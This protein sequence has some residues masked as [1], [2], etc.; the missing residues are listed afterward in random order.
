MP[1]INAAETPDHEKLKHACQVKDREAI[2]KLLEGVPANSWTI[3][4]EQATCTLGPSTVQVWHQ[5]GRSGISTYETA[6]VRILAVGETGDEQVLPIFAG[7]FAAEELSLPNYIPKQ[8]RRSS[9][10]EEPNA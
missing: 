2:S 10:A 9:A 1:E 3:T 5:W 8:R 4:E 7:Q 6:G